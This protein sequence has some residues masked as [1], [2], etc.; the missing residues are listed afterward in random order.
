MTELG[1]IQMLFLACVLPATQAAYLSQSIAV[2]MRCHDFCFQAEKLFS[3]S[4]F[5]NLGTE[6]TKPPRQEFRDLDQI[7]LLLWFLIH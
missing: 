3:K 7:L 2:I 5:T 1:F 4:V 6:R